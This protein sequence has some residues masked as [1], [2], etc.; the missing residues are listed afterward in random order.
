M[1]KLKCLDLCCKA[2]GTSMGY[3]RAGMD[4]VGVDIEPQ[5]HYPF[6][7]YQEDGLKF[8]EKNYGD[9]DLISA[10]PPCQRY[11]KSTKQWRKEG[12][13][14]PDLIL[15]FRQALIKSGKPYVIE[16]VPG[17]PL[18]SPIFLNGAMFG[19]FVHRPRFFECNF[20]VTQPIMPI[21]PKPVKMGRQVK[22]GEYIQPVGHFSNVSYAKKQM[23]IDWMVGEELAQ[24][25][26]PAYTR[27]IAGEWIKSINP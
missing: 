14:Y 1:K 27:Y 11:S 24:A 7:F 17:A 10:S 12:K 8:L 5:R 26:P 15:A 4:V 13:D 9:F 18:I 16:N 19:L 21:A 22:E 23:E 25:I 2:G 3:Y 6:R 20:L